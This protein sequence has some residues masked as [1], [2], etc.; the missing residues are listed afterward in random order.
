MDREEI[1]TRLSYSALEFG[2]LT[3]ADESLIEAIKTLTHAV[4]YVADVISDKGA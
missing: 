3:A 2:K 4:L 1:E